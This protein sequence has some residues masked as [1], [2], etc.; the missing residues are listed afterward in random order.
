MPV[1]CYVQ[2]IDGLPESV[3]LSD[4]HIDDGVPADSF[5]RAVES[6]EYWQKR[7]DTERRNAEHWHA[8]Y[9]VEQDMFLAA[10][11][12]SRKWRAAAIIGIGLLMLDWA[13]QTFQWFERSR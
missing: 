8:A 2:E 13:L 1:R 9:T 7:H 3:R 10:R 12:E 11:V 6:A 5:Q 4:S